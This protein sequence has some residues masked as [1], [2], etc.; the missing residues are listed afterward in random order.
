M[1]RSERP[2][3]T[4]WAPPSDLTALPPFLCSDY[5]LGMCASKPLRPNPDSMTPLTPLR[6]VVLASLAIA[7]GVAGKP[8]LGDE[9]Q[10]FFEEHIRPI[11]KA[12][13][14]DCHGATEELEGSLDL[15]Q[16][17]LMQ[18]GGDSGPAIIRGDAETSLLLERVR[19]GEM[20]PGDTRIS[21]EE[22]D[23]LTQWVAAGA[24]TKRPEAETIEPG[25][26]ITPEERAFWAFQP[27]VW[28]T[29]SDAAASKCSP[30]DQLLAL[31]S[32]A[33]SAGDASAAGVPEPADRRTLVLRA[34]LTLTG[35]PPT[36]QDVLRWQADP[37][38]D[39][40][41]HLTDE[42]LASPHYGERW[43]RHWLDVAGYADSEGATT[44]D[45]LRP[46]AWKYRDYVVR[47]FNDDLPFDRFI[48]E[49]L[50]GDELAGPQQGDW[51]DEQIRLLTA[52]GFLRMAA[53]GT[54]SGGD[55][56]EGRN[57]TIADTVRIVGT[58]FLGL[59]VH[60][61]QCHDHRYDP[62]LHTDYTALRA[63]F[64]PALD[65]QAW[66]TPSARLISLQTEA[67]RAKAAE[68]EAEAQ[69]VAAE[70][71][72]KQQA[73]IAEAVEM[74]LAKFEE[75][76]RAQ[77]R[78][79]RDTAADAR[80]AEQ[81]A[82]LKSHP[83][84]NVTPGVLYQYLPKAAEE[85]KAFDARIAEI[86][87]T[88]PAESFVRGLVEPAGHAPETRL[89]HR[90]DHAQPKQVVSARPPLVVMPED[91]VLTFAHD[92]SSLPTTGRRLALARWLAS[93]DNPLTSRVI[94]NRIWMH[95]FGTGLVATPAD[96]GT[97]GGRPSHPE[98]LDWLAADFMEHG[99]SLKHLHRTIMQSAAWQQPRDGGPSHGLP[100]TLVRL[101]AEAIR[102]RMLAITGR[103]DATLYGPPLPVK[104]DDT[105]QT[106]V[107]G[108]QSRR[109][110][111]IQQRRS[112]PVAMLQAFDAPVMETNC[113]AR[114]ISTVATQS[115]ILLNGSYILEQAAVVAERAEALAAAINTAAV[116]GIE[117]FTSLLSPTDLSPAAV[118]AAWRLAYT[119]DPT[120]SELAA[121]ASFA[122]EQLTTLRADP[123]KL[124]EGRSPPQQVLINI[125]QVLLSSNEFLTIE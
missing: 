109:S 54:G 99:W 92:D 59:S 53:D 25:L 19:S 76:L 100:T 51:T 39:W 73:F 23:T 83:S 108:Q 64:E 65:W 91:A 112:Q 31:S 113:E 68:I 3:E 94:V 66:K 67:E 50:A 63:V 74:E 20:P 24:A 75:P 106:V 84:V 43:A 29:L 40:L 26:G 72:Q 45:A 87:S 47:A 111:Y 79:A 7:L 1:G 38:D 125:C 35:L 110:L 105:G 12:H 17:R 14:F 57:Q 56:P 21:P 86:R 70:K 33:A 98:L 95:H 16:V 36:Y 90:G 82:L 103:L 32:T 102:D 11:L 44:A 114:P 89:F 55:T 88:K 18:A 46:W 107:D 124:V 96:F 80:T 115:L 60:C 62:F 85:L 41:A 34:F 78:A 15:R 93:A 49:Q 119:R 69:K 52:T 48:A 2:A 61:A 101:D 10:L 77:L 71:E 13:C 42:L 117:A 120:P 5:A 118:V 4:H 27:L 121:I 9:P 97:L 22:L 116:P 58:S 37:R 28:P 122:R 104:E 123:S 6:S 30:I 8:G 81:Q